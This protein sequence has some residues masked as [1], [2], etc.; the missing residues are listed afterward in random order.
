MYEIRKQLNI[1]VPREVNRAAHLILLIDSS[2]SL[3][4]KIIRAPS[5]GKKIVKLN[6]G[7]SVILSIYKPSK[8]D[9]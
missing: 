8:Y 2:L 5:K 3:I 7:H 9:N 1:N 4:G 6:I